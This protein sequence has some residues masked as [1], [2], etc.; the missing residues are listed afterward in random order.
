MRE[1]TFRCLANVGGSLLPPPDEITLNIENELIEKL[2]F[3]FK[4]ASKLTQ[5]PITSFKFSGDLIDIYKQ[6][7]KTSESEDD[8]ILN[9]WEIAYWTISE[10]ELSMVL[11]NL[12]GVQVSMSA[13][14]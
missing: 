8:D 7:G 11:E 2:E 13:E 6:M 10:G 12:N 1:L 5:L 4:E 14:L 9:G 3:G